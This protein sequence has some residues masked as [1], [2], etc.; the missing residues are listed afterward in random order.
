MI[1]SLLSD[2]LIPISSMV[3]VFFLVLA[4]YYWVTSNGESD[5]IKKASDS[6][7]NS[8]IGFIVILFA[9]TITQLIIFFVN[10][11]DFVDP[12]ATAS[13]IRNLEVWF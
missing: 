4:A 8:V 6:V 9:V 3:T 5:K 1:R 13:L 11:N 10:P 2:L 7:R 12:E